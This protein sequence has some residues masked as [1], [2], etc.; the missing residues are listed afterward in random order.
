[1]RLARAGLAL[2]GWALFA[3]SAQAQPALIF[4]L[5]GKNDKSFGQAASV[6]PWGQAAEGRFGGVKNSP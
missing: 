5:G 1:M 2:L 6:A 3:A 4:E